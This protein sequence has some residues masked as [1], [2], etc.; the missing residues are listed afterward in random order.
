M[1]KIISPSSIKADAEE[2][3]VGV[4]LTRIGKFLGLSL[5]CMLGHDHAN[6]VSL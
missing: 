3:S 4:T 5:S 2:S 6:H 1:N